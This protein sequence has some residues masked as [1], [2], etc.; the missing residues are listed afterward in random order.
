MGKNRYFVIILPFCSSNS[1]QVTGPKSQSGPSWKI[2]LK[3]L[4]A[5]YLIRPTVKGQNSMWIVTGLVPSDKRLESCTNNIPGIPLFMREECATQRPGNKRSTCLSLVKWK[6]ATV[7][8][9]VRKE[10]QL[11]G[12]FQAEPFGEREQHGK[13]RTWNPIALTPCLC[14]TW[15]VATALQ[16]ADS[17]H[18]VW[19]LLT[20]PTSGRSQLRDSFCSSQDYKYRMELNPD[21]PKGKTTY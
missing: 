10:N 7:Q 4:T 11:S 14:N 19:W 13:L 2:T 17:I 15:G 20:Q 1:F 21:Q 3:D 9:D 16:S 18:P 5:N 6:R 8:V 12:H